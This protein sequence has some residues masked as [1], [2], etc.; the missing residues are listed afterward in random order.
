MRRSFRAEV[1]FPK[2]VSVWRP[3]ASKIAD[4]S[5]EERQLIEQVVDLP[6][7]LQPLVA[8]QRSS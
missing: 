5:T 1:T 8:L 3:C 4:V 6:A 7:E 2:F